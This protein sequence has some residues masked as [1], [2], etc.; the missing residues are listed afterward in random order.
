MAIMPEPA[1]VVM[2][3]DGIMLPL[4]PPEGIMLA[5]VE[6]IAPPVPPPMEAAGLGIIELSASTA[7]TTALKLMG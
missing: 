3:P 7:V 6:A 1:S 5:P 4:T 2:A